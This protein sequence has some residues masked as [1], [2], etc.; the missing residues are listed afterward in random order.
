M[1]LP[2]GRERESGGAEYVRI[3][4]DQQLENLDVVRT[5]KKST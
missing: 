1:N 3:F 4:C 5:G 2:I